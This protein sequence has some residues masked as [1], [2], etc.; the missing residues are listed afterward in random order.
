MSD[1]WGD[2]LP[3]SEQVA[4]LCKAVEQGDTC[5]IGRLVS[6]FGKHAEHGTLAGKYPIILDI[7]DS[8]SKE[9]TDG[10]VALTLAELYLF[11]DMR[12]RDDAKAR[13]YI[14]RA[15]EQGNERAKSIL[16]G[17]TRLQSPFQGR[18]LLEWA[19]NDNPDE[20][21]LGPNTEFGISNLY[22]SAI[23]HG[24]PEAQF[25]LAECYSTGRVVAKD[26]AQSAWWYQMA[27]EQGHV[28]ATK[29]LAEMGDASTKA[30]MNAF[31][32]IV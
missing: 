12:V 14:R 16:G 27:A 19:V 32:Q 2:L 5:A 4:W 28:E 11:G 1:E 24:N 23:G 18:E 13:E 30:I 20:P 8:A 17:L 26:E 31:R 22:D 6:G 21:G 10:K 15:A 25:R 9:S 3:E 7:L 29:R